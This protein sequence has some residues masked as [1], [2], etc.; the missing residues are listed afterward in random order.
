MRYVYQISCL[1]S[2]VNEQD[3]E[4]A[5]HYKQAANLLSNCINLLAGQM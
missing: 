1:L 2:S 4:T 3:G 5:N